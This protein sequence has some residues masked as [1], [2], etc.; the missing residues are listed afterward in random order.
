MKPAVRLLSLLMA[1]CMLLSMLPVSTLAEDM[2]CE[3]CQQTD[4]ICCGSCGG[5][6]DAHMEGCP[7]TCL[8][9]DV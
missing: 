1:I 2:A 9:E 5:T 8:G 6:V 7:E 4:C 3:V